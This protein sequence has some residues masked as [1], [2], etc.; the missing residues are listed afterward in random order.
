MNSAEPAAS[1]PWA[2]TA[3]TI[4]LWRRRHAVAGLAVAL[5]TLVT[6]A[7][8]PATAS[9]NTYRVWYCSAGNDKPVVGAERDWSGTVAGLGYPP[10]PVVTC[11]GEPGVPSGAIS[12]EVRANSANSPSGA[13]HDAYMYAPADVTLRDVTLWWEGV[14]INGGQVTATAIGSS[15]QPL[16]DYRDTDFPPGRLTNPLPPPLEPQTY[17]LR[18]DT[19][20]LRLESACLGSAGTC[21]T[22]VTAYLRVHKAMVTAVDSAAP[23]GTASGS[24]VSDPVLTGAPSV[25]VAASDEGAGLYLLQALVDGKV[26]SSTPFA[27]WPCSDVDPSNG[28]PF[29]FSSVG[30]C[31]VR[32]I[33]TAE[34]DTAPLADDAY[35]RVEVRIVDAAGNATTVADRTVGVD[36]RLSLPGFFD[37]VTRR[38]QNPL[39]NL[40]IARQLNGHGAGVGAILRV[41]LPVT[42][43]A[44]IRHGKRKG[45]RTSVTRAASKRTVRFT[46][47]P[48]LRAVLTDV[49]RRP[50]ANAK[51]WVAARPKGQ[52]WQIAG[53]PQ[54][55]S[56]RGRVG[57][58]LPARS[59]SR[60]VNVV[61]FPFSDSHEQAVGRPVEVKVRA[62][63]SLSLSRRRARNGQSV[64][65]RGRVAGP[66]AKRGVTV[67]LQVKLGPRYRT[68]RSIRV[69]SSGRGRFRT[70]Y[71]F[72]ATSQATRYSF[73]AAVS[74]QS[75]MPYERGVSPIRTVV[76]T[77]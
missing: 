52:E 18:A 10:I 4:R 16:A 21:Q 17:A 7:A 49:A 54:T 42:R 15:D 46:S 41:Y 34:L 25:T 5:A 61:Y 51:V 13:V 70:R 12:T 45:H 26:Q 31:P 53:Q 73:R 77:P 67:S 2:R 14:A 35:H 33:L 76:V 6:G 56:S 22:N 24:L 30:P 48:T 11:P 72:A 55:T 20:R 66:L 1:T 63:V 3:E 58:R 62:G 68:F 64:S 32:K 39:L 47:H 40:A 59:P 27:K 60:Q 75:G 71:R 28:D 44:R 36:S 29:E 57:L 50:I 19:T 9:A 43:S 8:T 37:P 69:T 38:F 23:Q 65:F 74:R